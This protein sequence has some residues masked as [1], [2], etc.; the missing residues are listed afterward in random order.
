METKEKFITKV[1]CQISYQ[2]PE[3]SEIL[4]LITE[5]THRMRDG[6]TGLIQDSVSHEDSQKLAAL[7][8]V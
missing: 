6:L 5:I 4:L 7:N 8:T 1:K 3:L 2:F